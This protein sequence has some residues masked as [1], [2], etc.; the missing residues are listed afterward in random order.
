MR[1]QRRFDATARKISN[2]NTVSIFVRALVGFPE[3]AGLLL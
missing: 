2:F 1:D 3:H